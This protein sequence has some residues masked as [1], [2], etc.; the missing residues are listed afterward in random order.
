MYMAPADDRPMTQK[1]YEEFAKAMA[2]AELEEHLDYLAELVAAQTIKLEE[3]RVYIK[4][5]EQL[6][7]DRRDKMSKLQ[8]NLDELEQELM[9][10]K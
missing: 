4:V 2:E 8:K 1:E 10:L 9:R 3:Q 7:A 6:E 5:L